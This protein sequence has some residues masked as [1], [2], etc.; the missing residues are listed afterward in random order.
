MPHLP[1]LPRAAALAALALLAA[2][3]SPLVAQE[4]QPPAWPAIQAGIRFGYDNNANSTVLGAQV[5]IPVVRGA[6]LEVVP[7]GDVTFL[8]GLKEYQ[9]NADVVW[10]SGGRRGGLYAGAGLA[11]RNSI[12]DGPERETRTGASVLIGLVSRGFGDVPLGTQL[13]ARWVFL[14]ADF[15]PRVLTLGVNLPLWG[16]GDDRG[17][18][19]F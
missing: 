4:S 8:P 19:G 6:W 15:S 11:M 13:E 5:R 9:G 1:T 2:P 18:R 7:S 3:S 14:D 12:F 17:G 16:W 10:V